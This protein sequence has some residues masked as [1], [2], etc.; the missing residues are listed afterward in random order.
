MSGGARHSTT[1]RSRAQ[2][3][4]GGCSEFV[5]AAHRVFT[6]LSAYVHTLNRSKELYAALKAAVASESV[7]HGGEETRR[8]GRMLL[9]DFERGGVHLEESKREMVEK[10]EAHIQ[11]LSTQ[12]QK[13]IMEDTTHVDVFP[14]S[15]L[16]RLPKAVRTTLPSVRHPTTATAGRRVVTDGVRT[17]A[18][19][20]WIGDEEVSGTTAVLQGVGVMW[21]WYRCV[22]CVRL[23]SWQPTAPLRVTVVWWTTSSW[24]ATRWHNCS[25]STPTHTW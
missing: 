1:P 24:R 11:D 5:E 17:Q 2:G 14:A 9:S 21:C 3:Q 16:Q 7:R 12:Y 13:N 23:Y 8:V 4:A 10:L 6:H 22:R 15:R 20:K 25:G 18:V 19:L